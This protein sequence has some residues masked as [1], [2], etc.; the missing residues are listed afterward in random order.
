MTRFAAFKDEM[1]R[2]EEELLPYFD[3]WLF[4]AYPERI[5]PADD[6]WW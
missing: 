5:I 1:S 2:R 6:K 4:I 3:H